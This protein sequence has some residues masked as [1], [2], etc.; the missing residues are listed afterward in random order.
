LL[1]NQSSTIRAL[2]QQIK[3]HIAQHVKERIAVPYAMDQPFINYHA[4]KNG[5]CEN[6]TLKPHVALFEDVDHPPNEDTAAI[7]HFS[8]PI[9]NFAHKYGRMRRYFTTMLD[10]VVTPATPNRVCNVIGRTYSWGTGILHFI[11]DA[12]LA[13]TWGNGT[14]AVLDKNRVRV[15]WNNYYHV[16]EFTNEGRDYVGVRTFPS[17]FGI[18]VGTELAPANPPPTFNGTKPTPLCSIMEKHGSDKGSLTM[19]NRHN[20]TTL[21]YEL[22]KSWRLRE[23]RVFE[24]GLGTNFTDVKSNMGSNGKPGASLRGWAEFFPNARIFGADIDKRVL[25]QEDRI[26]TFYCDQL[27]PVAIKGMWLQKDLKEGFDLIVE[28]GLHEYAANVCFFENSIRKLKPG[29]IYSIE[30]IRSQDLALFVKKLNEWRSTYTDFSFHLAC[31]D[32]AHNKHDN[33]LLLVTRHV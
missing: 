1:F 6:Q 17:D 4:I 9:G 19:R 28:D 29:G 22:L 30:D 23:L 32:H 20:Y 12:T 2:F 33:N 10:H 11:N 27:D 8:F 25:F 24:L 16:I 7:C 21:Y 31:I 14:Y 18:C 5:M 13:T 3:T 26:Q 15:T